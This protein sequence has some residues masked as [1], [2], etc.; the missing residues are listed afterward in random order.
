MQKQH[1]IK[2]VICKKQKT[3]KKKNRLIQFRLL[4]LLQI[5]KKNQSEPGWCLMECLT[6]VDHCSLT[7][8]TAPAPFL[9]SSA[10]SSSYLPERL[11][12]FR[13]SN[14]GATTISKET[15]TNTSVTTNSIHK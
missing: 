12:E 15:T 14:G 5:A 7:L 3:K 6:A 2:L 1:S 10:W 4:L 11:Q 8:R 9:L 13:E